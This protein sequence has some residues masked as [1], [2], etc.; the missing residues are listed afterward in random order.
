M[1]TSMV[2]CTSSRQAR[3]LITVFSRLSIRRKLYEPNEVRQF[4]AVSG[5]IID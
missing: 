4:M 2:N 5:D 3:P 1:S